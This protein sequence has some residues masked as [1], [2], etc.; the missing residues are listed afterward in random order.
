MAREAKSSPDSGVTRATSPAKSPKKESFPSS[1]Y[2]IGSVIVINR[3]WKGVKNPGFTGGVA[4]ITDIHPPKSGGEGS[5]D[6]IGFTY[7]VKYLLLSRN[8]KD[9]SPQFMTGCAD[10]DN[11]EEDGNGETPKRKRRSR[12]P[13]RERAIPAPLPILS[14]KNL[15]PVHKTKNFVTNAT[16]PESIALKMPS[17]VPSKSPSKTPSNTPSKLDN[18]NSNVNTKRPWEKEEDKKLRKAVKAHTSDGSKM[19][20]F[21]WQLIAD[22]I[23][24]RTVTSLQQRWRRIDEP[25]ELD[26]PS[27]EKNTAARS[28]KLRAPRTPPKIDNNNNNTIIKRPWEEKEDKKLRKAIKAHTSD[29][30]K[31]SSAAWQSIADK[32]N[33]RTVISLQYRWKRIN[34]PR[35]LNSP[36]REKN[37]ADTTARSPKLSVPRTPPKIDNNNKNNSTFKRAWTKEEDIKLQKVI[38]DHTSDG[39]ISAWQSIADN[40]S[41]RTV[42]SL[43]YR[44]RRMGEI[45]DVEPEDS[46]CE[47][48]TSRK[49]TV[50]ISA[51]DDKSKSTSLDDDEEYDGEMSDI[52]TTE[53]KPRRSIIKSPNQEKTKVD[54]TVLW[55]LLTSTDT[56]RS[57]L[58]T[59]EEDE[60]LRTRVMA[61]EADGG[62]MNSVAW[63]E[64]SKDLEDRNV[65]A[66]ILRWRR[67]RKNVDLES[68]GSSAAELFPTPVKQTSDSAHASTESMS[69]EDTDTSEA[70]ID[71]TTPLKL[72]NHEHT[73]VDTTGLKPPD[74]TV[75]DYST[76][77]RYWTKEEDFKLFKAVMAQTSDGTINPTGWTSIADKM[78]GR[79]EKALKSRWRR[80]ADNNEFEKDGM[81]DANM[82][83]PLK[84]SSDVECVKPESTKESIDEITEPPQ[85]KNRNIVDETSS[86]GTSLKEELSKAATIEQPIKSNSM[87]KLSAKGANDGLSA[88]AVREASCRENVS[89]IKLETPGLSAP[90][91]KRKRTAFSPQSA[92]KQNKSVQNKRSTTTRQIA[93]SAEKI[94]LLPQ[95]STSMASSDL[96]ASR[97]ISDAQAHELEWKSLS[98]R[99]DKNTEKVSLEEKAPNTDKMTFQDKMEKLSELLDAQSSH[100]EYA[101]TQK[102]DCALSTFVDQSIKHNSNGKRDK[103][104]TVN[105]GNAIIE[106]DDDDYDDHYDNSVSE[107][108]EMRVSPVQSKSTERSVTWTGEK[109]TIESLHEQDAERELERENL[110]LEL[111]ETWTNLDNIPLGKSGAKMMVTFGDGRNPVPEAVA[112]TLMGTRAC[113]QNAVKDSRALRRKLVTDFRRARTL[114]NMHNPR[115]NEKEFHE[116]IFDQSI[117]PAMMYR[118]LHGVDKLGFNPKCGFDGSQLGVLFPEEMSEYHKWEELHKSYLNNKEAK[119]AGKESKNPSIYNESWETGSNVRA[120]A[121][122]FDARTNQMNS[123]WYLKFT[124][125]RR[126]SFL[127]R[128]NCAEDREWNKARKTAKRSKRSRYDTSW[129]TL[130]AAM[131]QFLHWIG[132]DQR[133][134]IPP[135][136]EGTTEALAF[137]GYDFMGKIVEK[138]I[139]LRKLEKKKNEKNSLLSARARNKALLELEEGEQ[140]QLEDIKRALDDTTLNTKP[141]YNAATS[142]SLQK[143]TANAIQLY[144]GR[145]FENRLEM[146]LDQIVHAGQHQREISEEEK[147]IRLNED[148]LF[149]KMSVPPTMLS[150]VR[151]VLGSELDTGGITAPRNA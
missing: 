63:R 14:S 20:A 120:R 66:L 70:V 41:G 83:T 77:K 125:V 143:E 116:G 106:M 56:K 33:G 19:N 147:K 72:P 137:L 26:S 119:D 18:D 90:V 50:R 10:S 75:D 37:I 141:L 82:T 60:I 53:Q 31:M 45:N 134:A 140:L 42:D 149:D 51:D 54:S 24:G 30:S 98:A 148:Q 118:V 112:A 17:K 8:D 61:E 28:P 94:N 107:E 23:S 115:S 21:A 138:A 92:K 1:A 99:S 84:K 12:T 34:E 91:S 46:S 71:H 4:R 111:S 96:P 113:L 85:D 3:E 22:K 55:S 136:N 110:S 104:L 103:N 108:A 109:A 126:G 62:K 86:K 9:V 47:K 57:S 139:F 49:D 69:L 16:S 48:T 129:E 38:L 142:E 121:L 117:E 151:D 74:S 36:S 80:I 132:F 88:G 122:M 102:I 150:E 127:P 68:H 58:W 128:A 32:M 135:P 93:S 44:W 11:D 73:S 67:L 35:D 114:S 7:D 124:E 6:D 64:I 133:S 52:N 78:T 89:I 144:F 81:S 40:M 105:T 95:P 100:G 43:K 27:H 131:V 76:I 146:E 2:S 79:T 65:N 101:D 59:K 29:G 145:G 15:L 13:T 39:R 25:C 97:I 123:D 5:E 87:D 130:P